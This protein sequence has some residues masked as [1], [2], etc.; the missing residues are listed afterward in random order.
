MGRPVPPMSERPLANRHLVSPRYFSTLG[1]PLRAGRDFDEEED[2]P[3][4]DDARHGDDRRREERRLA[5][6]ESRRR[7]AP[8]GAREERCRHG[9]R[10]EESRPEPP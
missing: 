10:H 4:G 2:A 1:I 6:E 7:G 3:P 9:G 5:G 8:A